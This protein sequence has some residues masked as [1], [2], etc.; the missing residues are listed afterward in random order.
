MEL[1]IR[2][3]R[4]IMILRN[5]SYSST[6]SL[7]LRQDAADDRVGI[8]PVRLGAG[9]AQHAMPQYGMRHGADILAGHRIAPVEIG[10]GLPAQ[11]QE[12]RSARPRAQLTY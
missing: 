4:S 5:E 2:S 9:V 8:Q 1:V 3:S 12:L 6:A 11:N 10:A 7:Q